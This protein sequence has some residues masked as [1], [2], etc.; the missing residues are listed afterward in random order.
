MFWERKILTFTFKRTAVFIALIAGLTAC[1][2]NGKDSSNNSSSIAN[3]GLSQSQYANGKF[4]TYGETG[5]SYDDLNQYPNIGY[6][7]YL[8]KNSLVFE[9]KHAFA[10]D[11]ESNKNNMQVMATLIEKAVEDVP[12]AM[13]VTQAKLD[14]LVILSPKG[15]NA[16]RDGSRT[17]P[18]EYTKHVWELINS[19]GKKYNIDSKFLDPNNSIFNIANVISAVFYSLDSNDAKWLFEAIVTKNPNSDYYNYP[20]KDFLY[21]QK[22]LVTANYEGSVNSW[23]EGGLL[24]V[25]MT[26][27]SVVSRQEAVQTTLHELVHVYS[28]KIEAPV[29]I[30][31][32]QDYPSWFSEGMATYLSGQYLGNKHPAAHGDLSVYDYDNYAEGISVMMNKFGKDTP[33]KILYTMRDLDI[34][35]TF[36]GQ[37]NECPVKGATSNRFDCALKMIT[38]YNQ[39][40]FMEHYPEL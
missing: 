12:S 26:P 34:K 24:G 38:G 9:T 3:D 11:K 39:T 6:S 5:L 23:A 14:N 19:V 2:G 36:T 8:S 35:N 21:P 16:F 29:S 18:E 17:I 27:P 22:L 20:I 7:N 28:A 25:H 40:E 10:F 13:N 30:A 4:V 1:G 33:V 31:S 15:E 37:R 32:P